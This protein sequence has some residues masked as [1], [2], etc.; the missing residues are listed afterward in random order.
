MAACASGSLEIVKYFHNQIGIN[1]YC[2][3]NDGQNALHRA[4]HFGE[5]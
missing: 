4:C 2:K 5:L 1:T 3:N